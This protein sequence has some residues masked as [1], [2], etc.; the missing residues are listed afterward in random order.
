MRFLGTVVAGEG[1]ASVNYE[2]LIL[3]AAIY[4]PAIR[5]CGQF[6][7]INV[8]LD[9]EID[10]SFADYWTPPI[11]WKPRIILGESWDQDLDR[12]EEFGFVAVKFERLSSGILYDAWI[13]LPSGHGATYLND[14]VEIVAAELIDGARLQY[15]A[16]CAIRLDHMP[17]MPR[18]SKFGDDYKAGAGAVRRTAKTD[19]DLL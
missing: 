12:Q 9:Q 1:Y 4:Y 2:R 13:V 19:D 6:G 5:N 14:H 3:A 17:L 11:Y 18:P 16:R 10:K 7:T 15:G 8:D